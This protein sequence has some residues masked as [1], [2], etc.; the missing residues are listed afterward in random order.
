MRPTAAIRCLIAREHMV[1]IELDGKKVEVAPGSMVMHAAEKAG[2]LHSALLL[3]QEAVDCGQLPHVPGRGGKSAQS[4]A[5]LCYACDPRH[6]RAHQEQKSL[7]G[8]AI[9]HGIPAHQPPA[10]LP[11]LRPGW[12]VPVAGLGGRLRCRHIPLW[13][14]KARGRAQGYRPPDVHRRDEPL[15]PLHP[16]RAL[17]PRNRRG[18]GAGHGQSRRARRNHHRRW[19]HAWTPSCRAT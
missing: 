18:D 11:H 12:R 2:A 19:R 17:W 3:S 9:G 7:G 15:H 5:R 13:R 4:L 16:L 8:A 14:R 1:E 6:D 10:G